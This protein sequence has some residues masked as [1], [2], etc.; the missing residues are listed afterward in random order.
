[1]GSMNGP[2][3]EGAGMRS[4]RREQ[5]PRIPMPPR[6]VNSFAV[7]YTPTAACFLSERRMKIGSIVIHCYDFD[8]TVAFWQ[9]ALHYL[10]RQPAKDGW[11]VLRDPEGKGPNL[12]FQGRNTRP[13]SRSWVHSI[14]TRRTRKPKS[15]DWSPW[16]RDDIR[17]GTTLTT[18]LSCW[19]TRAA[20]SSAS[21]RRLS[22]R[23]TRY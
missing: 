5:P 12:S 13:R 21:S 6:V 10:P 2:E 7:Q 14:C 1:M 16:E 18:I 3:R 22:G 11:V 15:S 17:G 9:A 20:P 4:T 23:L 8:R 19:R